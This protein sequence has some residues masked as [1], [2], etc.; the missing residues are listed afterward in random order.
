MADYLTT[1][2]E[3]TSVANAIR[4]KGG[5]S[6]SLI[7]PTGFVSAIQAISTGTDVSDT[8]LTAD[9]ALSGYYFYNSSG[10]K[11]QGTVTEWSGGSYGGS[12]IDFTISGVS[13]QAYNGMTWAQWCESTFDPIYSGNQK[14]FYIRGNSTVREITSEEDVRNPNSNKVSPTDTIVE[15][16]A[17]IIDEP[18]MPL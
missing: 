17:Y 6:A 7:Y 10:T 18:V 11:V 15:N 8:T 5:T 2:T 4:T 1:D 12:T 14:K 16:R 13:Y 9:K 3:L